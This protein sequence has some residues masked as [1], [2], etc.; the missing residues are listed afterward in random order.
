M[1]ADSPAL[2]DGERQAP[3]DED[4]VVR[5][6]TLM[7]DHDELVADMAV[8][9]AFRPLAF[10]TVPGKSVVVPMFRPA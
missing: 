10:S 7:V 6:C 3:I 1:G 5:L 4:P 2:F 8:V 9:V